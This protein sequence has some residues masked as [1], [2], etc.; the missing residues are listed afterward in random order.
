MNE[1]PIVKAIHD[2]LIKNNQMIS[3]AESC[4]GGRIA[5]KMTARSGCSNCFWGS[6]VAYSNTCKMKI[7][8]V[9]EKTLKNHGAVS[10]QTAEEMANNL[11]ELS[12]CDYSLSVTGIAGPE[13]GCPEKPVGTVWFGMSGKKISTTSWKMLFNGERDSIIEQATLHVLESFLR[14]VSS[15]N[16]EARS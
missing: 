14:E 3:F 7:L 15:Q 9:S 16:S 8:K 13:G 12:G 4:T 1:P 6:I 10:S 5:A 11:L 2:Y